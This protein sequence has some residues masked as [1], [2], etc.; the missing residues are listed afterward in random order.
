MTAFVVSR[1][2]GGEKFPLDR[3]FSDSDVV[4]RDVGGEGDRDEGWVPSADGAGEGVRESVLDGEG[5]RPVDDRSR[6][7][8][9]C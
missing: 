6:K 2:E 8:G 9:S 7:V 4:E 3:L 1:K 5:E